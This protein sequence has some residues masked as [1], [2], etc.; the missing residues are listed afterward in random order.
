MLKLFSQLVFGPCVGQGDLR[1]RIIDDTVA[2]IHQNGIETLGRKKVDDLPPGIIVHP[3]SLAV[4]VAD[5]AVRAVAD[6]G[7]DVVPHVVA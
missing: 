5:I 3:Q 4:I 7:D 6:G 2:H 1:V